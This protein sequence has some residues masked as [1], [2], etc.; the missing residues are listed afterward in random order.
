PGSCRL[1]LVEV[2]SLPGRQ[3]AACALRGG[4]GLVVRT[5]TPALAESRRFGLS[6]LLARYAD[7]GYAA[8]DPEGT[9]FLPWGRQYGARPFGGAQPAPCHPVDSDSGPFVWVD[10]NKC[11]LCTR[12][13]RACAEVQ[14]R[15]VLGVGYRGTDTRIVAGTGGSLL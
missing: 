15:F 8:G 13:V 5:E 10:L 12:C 9:E 6:L 7:P 2:E 4:G 1:C 14:A 3:A 11:I